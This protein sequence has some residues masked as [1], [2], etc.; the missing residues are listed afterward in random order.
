MNSR[1]QTLSFVLLGFM[2]LAL[3][4]GGGYYFVFL[5]LQK[6]AAESQALESEIADLTTKAE[7]Q[8]ATAKRLSQARVRSL[9]A[10]QTLA[11]QEY[12][13][14]L[15]RLIDSAG[16]P[17]GYTITPKAV[18]NSPRAVPEITKGKLVY[19][20]VAYEVVLKKVNMW[21]IK[22]FLEDYY[23]LG[24]LHQITAIHIKKEDDNN[25]KNANRRDDLTVTLTTEAIIVDGADTRKTLLPV[26]TAYAAIAGGA[27]YKSLTLSRE[28]ARGVAPQAIVPVLAKPERD[29]SL[30]VLK[31]PFC[32]PLPPPPPPSPFKLDKINDVKIVTDEKPKPIKVS[33]Q[34][35]GSFG[36]RITA[37]ASGTLFA[38]GALKIDPKTN[39]IELPT[40]SATEGT[41][42]ISVIATSADGQKTEKTTFKVT[43]IGSEEQGPNGPKKVDDRE[44][45]SP[46]IILI[47]TAP[48]SDGTAW[49]RVKD[50]ANRLR[51]E[52][53]AKP[54][55]VSIVKEWSPSVDR[56]KKDLDYD[57]PPGVLYISDDNTK[58][59]RTFKVVA[60]DTEGLILV[61]LKPDAHATV[62]PKGKGRPG[63]VGHGPAREGHDD[64]LA[65]L[66]GNMV[67]AVPKPK[68]YRWEVGQ[69][70]AKLR[71]IP[72]D[73]AKK[74]L[75]IAEATGPVFDVAA[76]ER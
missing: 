71:E 57:Q 59:K 76:T 27:I 46:F 22:Q 62:P 42:T 48:R 8:Q 73:D 26:P 65:A 33:V 55:G 68:L 69:T 11:Q 45:I 18:D 14:A 10:D 43:V 49:A 25:A 53:E 52:I 23:K 20:R 47:G 66:G 17:K 67:V 60:V 37:I 54:K 21:M 31:D 38:E 30:I 36:A 39:A 1:E 75:R 74:I 19:T 58:T 34:G 72:E 35:D 12:T 40:T 32:G 70:L 28:V 7:E 50:N 13:V 24:L 51:Y 9:P 6:A 16:V 2:L 5:P 63:K 64:P 56:W 29:Y 41:S 4:G 3:A 15:E 44:D 61:D